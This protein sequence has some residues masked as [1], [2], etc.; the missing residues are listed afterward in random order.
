MKLNH[1]I[2]GL[3]CCVLC[4]I[5]CCTGLFLRY[6]ANHMV[7]DPVDVD[8]T[9][10]PTVTQYV[11]VYEN[12]EAFEYSAKTVGEV[13]NCSDAESKDVALMLHNMLYD[14]T[15]IDADIMLMSLTDKTDDND[16]VYYVMTDASYVYSVHVGKIDDAYSVSWIGESDYFPGLELPKE[17]DD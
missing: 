10:S 14:K 3:I 9:V 15:G 5:L 1:R 11:Y 12:T 8:G 4:L 2:V 6:K 13:L 7:N 16:D 17:G